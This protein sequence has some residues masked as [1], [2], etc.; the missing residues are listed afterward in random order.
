MECHTMKKI[1]QGGFLISKIHQL[2]GRIFNRLLKE[3][4]IEV[5]NSA[6]GRI[7][8]VLWQ[9]DGI[10]IQELARA[11]SLGKSTLTSMLDRLENSGFI[12]RVPSKE[13]R[14]KILIYRTEKDRAFQNQYLKISE[15]M[16]EIWYEHLSESAI[17]K[18]EK[19]LKRIFQNLE[20]QDRYGKS[21]S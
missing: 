10:P 11:T 19:T 14:R 3:H 12:K 21:A 17:E 2:S 4:G 7:L 13:D 18:F 1:R 6:Q 8:F 5:V 16:T 20:A 15:E 9:N